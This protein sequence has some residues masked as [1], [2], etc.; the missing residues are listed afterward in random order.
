MTRPRAY[1][2]SPAPPTLCG[3]ERRRKRNMKGVITAVIAAAL[4]AA[5]LAWPPAKPTDERL[6]RAPLAFGS[7][8]A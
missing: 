4:V 5:I 1:R 8:V 3:R 2:I 7:E 6:P